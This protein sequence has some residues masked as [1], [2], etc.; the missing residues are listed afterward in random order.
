[1]RN[2]FAGV[3]LVLV[4]CSQNS[5]PP[6]YESDAFTLYP[7]RVIQGVYQARAVSAREIVSDY[8]NFGND[9]M[10]P[11]I[12]FK[13]AINGEDNEMLS[14]RDHH[15]SCL[16]ENGVCETPLITFGEQY[17]DQRPVPLGV[18]LKPETKWKVRLDMRHVFSAFETKGYYETFDGRRIAKDEFESVYIAGS[19]APLTWDF[20]TLREYTHLQLHDE[21]GDHIYEIE[22]VL[23]QRSRGARQ[24]W[25]LSL[26]TDGYPQLESPMPLVDALYNLSLEEMVRAVEED[27]TLRTGKEWSG[28]WTRDVSYSTIL[29]MAILQPKVARY[30]L[31]RKVKDGMIIQD[32]GTG[33]A[34]PVSTDRMI[35]AV[36][37]WEIYLVTGDRNWLETMYP[38]IRKSLEA[39]LK[40]AYDT[41][42]GLV[43]GESSFLDWREQTYPAWMTPADIYSSFSLGTNAVH[44]QANKILSD[45]AALLGDV[46]VAAYHRGVAT[47][48]RNGIN[49]HLWVEDQQ[50]FGQYLYG[51][52]FPILS[53]RAEALGAALCVL[54]DIA[55]SS[56]QKQVVE[57]MP[58]NAFGI[59]CIYPQIPDIPPY[60]NNGVWPFVQSYWALASARAGNENAVRDALAAVW[61]P[62]SLF[63]TNK[64]NFVAHT[65]DYAATQINSDNMLWSLSGN[66]ALVYRIL[67]GISYSPDHVSFSPFV[68]QAMAGTYQLKGYRYRDAVLDIEVTG[69]GNVISRVVLDDQPINEARLPAS[70]TGRHSLRIE[71]SNQS[72]GGSVNKSPHRESPRAPQVTLAGPVLSWRTVSSADRYRVIRNGDV[73][74]EQN[75]TTF[76]V[77]G[78]T[79]GEYQ[80]IAI[81]ADGVESFASEPVEYAP[82]GD[83]SIIESEKFNA[84]ESQY[85]GYSGSGYVRTNTTSTRNVSFVVD[86]PV[87]GTYVVDFRY[88]NGHGPVNTDN[89][90]AI[91]SLM[92][93]DALAGTVVFPQRGSG[94]WSHWG[95]S[96]RLVLK[97]TKGRHDIWLTYLSHNAN[98]NGAVN[99]AAI[100]YLRL[101]RIQ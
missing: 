49:Q 15:F 82:K 60:H 31:M 101:V 90:C 20:P 78:V 74:G 43:R 46:D 54:F 29:S 44:Y 61:R 84:G 52:A 51:R 40:N 53:P 85:S 3:C 62:A 77:D 9:Y 16:T 83:I 2:L 27:S 67:F 71:L 45:V 47:R 88:A 81:D 75:D 48:I 100:D 21:D 7:D 87:S 94:V 80:V 95:F 58:I 5:A 91:R 11:R 70:L 55:D 42:L 4:S 99:E 33:G 57:N 76:N 98:M 35:W 39:D 25:K 69:F 68:P 79:Y 56:R 34:Y 30:S 89:K 59:P 65:G 93:D 6:V 50:N 96:N 1:M 10:P 22:L 72:A 23:N 12:D 26:A 32:T 13:F 38:I 86:V 28:V 63:L 24:P 18:Y 14:G 19:T 37:A 73:V 92:V 36:A 64:E 17:D 8:E 97:L 41:E 66:L